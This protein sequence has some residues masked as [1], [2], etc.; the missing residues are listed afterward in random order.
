[1]KHPNII[2]MVSDDHG[3]ETLG[4]YGNSVVKTPSMDQLADEGVKF[5][6]AFCTTSSCAASRSVILTGQQNHTNGTYGHVHGRHHFSCFDDT[7]TLPAY[8]NEAG[9]RTGCVGKKH[10]APES[11]FPFEYDLSNPDHSRNDIMMSEECRDFIEDDEPFFLY[12]CSHN[13]H[14]AGVIEEHPLKPNNFG[15][16]KKAYPGDTEEI[17]SDDEV[18]VPFFLN[19]TLEVRAELAQY[20]QS[21]SRLD[22][23]IGHLMQILKDAGKYDNT[24]VIYISDNGAAFPEA[25]TNL[26]EPGM[27][28]PC[29]VKSPLH[30]KHGGICNGL[31]S[32]ADLTPTILDFAGADFEKS[33]F[34]GHSFKKIID[35]EDPEK[36]RKEVYASHTFHE[37]T[38]YYPMRVVR[39]HKYKFIWNIA[40]PLTYPSGSDLWSSCS[41]QRLLRDG[42]NKFGSRTVEAYLHRPRFELYDLENDPEEI[43]NLSDQLKYQDMVEDFSAKLKKFQEETQDQWISKWIHE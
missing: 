34:N 36:W 37:I 39:T 14:R 13:P 33:D 6:N 11:L 41:W 40:H 30:K 15:N 43:N 17:Y 2:L 21:I 25:K 5:T 1:M 18:E 10:Y 16:P 42:S 38:N 9:Y 31:V 23:G 35:Q 32:W 24:V 29:I 27:N 12:W 3:I 22:R 26:Y 20:Y 7:K 4:C 8:L 19:D 28:L